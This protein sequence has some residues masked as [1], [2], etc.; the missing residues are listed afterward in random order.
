MGN[1]VG[2]KRLRI[3]YSEGQTL[4]TLLRLCLASIALLGS[5]GMQAAADWC[6]YFVHNA[7]SIVQGFFSTGK[8]E[9]S[10]G[11]NAYT[12][13]YSVHDPVSKATRY[14]Y[15]VYYLTGSEGAWGLATPG[16]DQ[17]L[18]NRYQSIQLLPQAILLEENGQFRFYNYDLELLSDTAWDDAEAEIRE[19]GLIDCDLIRVRKNGLYGAVDLTGQMVI[20]PQY[21]QFD[22]YTYET[23]WH[24]NRVKQNGK[25]GYIDRNGNSIVSIQYDFA[26]MSTVKVYDDDEDPN[27]PEAGHDREVVYV[28]SDDRWGVMY[29][30][31]DG[32]TGDVTWDVEPPQEMLEAARAQQAVGE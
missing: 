8:E 14:Y 18:E 30:R 31:A 17:L 26:L 1:K 7:G 11:G 28:L 2:T 3:K 25:Y 29:K 21:E 6:D 4:L 22:L 27:D 24:I 16:G 23:N 5:W 10:L 9:Q 20:E 19:D 32:S 15:S 12:L 13:Y